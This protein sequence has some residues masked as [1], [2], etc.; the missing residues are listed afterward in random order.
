MI[1][2]K[3]AD[4]TL[5]EL[6]SR[7]KKEKNRRIKERLNILILLKEEYPQRDISSFLH[8]SVGKVPFWKARFEEE[9]FEGLRD[10]RGRGRKSMLSKQQLAGLKKKLSNPLKMKNG[11]TRGWQTKDVKDYIR[12]Q[13]GINF[14][15]RNV[16][17]ILHKLD[18]V[19]L[20]PRP[21][22]MNRNQESVDDFKKRSML[23]S[24][25]WIPK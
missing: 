1:K 15:V 7:F 5:D 8:I 16:R 21:R 23:N 18:M 13:Y 10:K 2:I 4:V 11:Y 19:R 6:N 12:K 17:N 9:G 3:L 25:V 20:V 22:H 24:N 14:K